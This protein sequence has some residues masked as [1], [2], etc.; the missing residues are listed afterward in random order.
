MAK[1]SRGMKEENSSTRASGL[2]HG[3]LKRARL[4]VTCLIDRHS[5]LSGFPVSMVDTSAT[6]HPMA[7]AKTPNGYLYIHV[8]FI[9]WLGQM[10]MC[11]PNLSPATT[12]ALSR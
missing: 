4:G 2:D 3:N 9:S 1:R 11:L 8:W 10:L 12:D 5:L 7:L 6:V